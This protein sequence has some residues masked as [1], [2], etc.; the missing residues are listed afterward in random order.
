[1]DRHSI[2][3]NT[4]EKESK[5]AANENQHEGAGEGR[6]RQTPSVPSKK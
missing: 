5:E 6:S 3:M 1:M 2:V 4:E